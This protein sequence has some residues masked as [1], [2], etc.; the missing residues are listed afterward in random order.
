MKR[1][2]A[3][4]PEKRYE[5]PAVIPV[6]VDPVKD[7]LTQCPTKASVGLDCGEDQAFFYT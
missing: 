7:M 1:E 6:H 3:K 4:K 2:T 5:P